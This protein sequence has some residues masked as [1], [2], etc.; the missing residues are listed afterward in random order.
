MPTCHK[1]PFR[2]SSMQRAA[3]CPVSPWREAE[4]PELPDSEISD[5]GT[6][7]HS[8]IEGAFRRGD[9]SGLTDYQRG[10]V[11]GC[12]GL[13]E[14]HT[15]GVHPDAVLF[16]HELPVMNRWGELIFDRPAHIDCLIFQGVGLADICDWKFGYK[17]SPFTASHDLQGLCYAVAVRNAYEG[18]D[19]VGFNRF[20]PR[21]WNENR[22]TGVLYAGDNDYWASLEDVIGRVVRASH[23][24]SSARPGHAQCLYCKAKVTCAEFMEW[25]DPEKALKQQDQALPLAPQRIAEILEYRDRLKLLNSRMA[26]V[27]SLAKQALASGVEIP[28]WQLGKPRSTRS[29]ENVAEASAMLIQHMP[30]AAI[31][32]AL[33]F[34]VPALETA[35][36][37]ATGLKGKKASEEFE[38]ILNGYLVTT[39]SAPSLRRAKEIE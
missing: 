18:I 24:G 6:D 19:R 8:R 38:R 29:I 22:L 26:D 1:L 2:P 37:A 3:L 5:E 28:G 25:A 21:L 36:K 7:L 15:S 4:I 35:F 33:A 31:D 32:S 23:P 17:E 12:I 30:L 14:K 11:R 27:E 34:S 10:A 20:H 9:Y 16:E 13:L 39:E